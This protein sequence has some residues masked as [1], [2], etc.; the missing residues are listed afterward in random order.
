MCECAIH[1]TYKKHDWFGE[2]KY[3]LADFFDKWWDIYTQ[4]PTSFIQPE[5]YKAVN[6]IRTCRTAA[7]GID[8]YACPQ[9]GDTTEIYHNCK[10]RFCPTCSWNDTVRWAEK[11]KKNML[12]MPHR[13]VVFTIPHQ[14][15]PLIKRNEYALLNM[16]IQVSADTLKSWIEHKYGLR[17]G[18]ISVLHTFGELK[19]FHSH[20]HMIV[21]WGGV[22]KTG[23]IKEIKGEYVKY[24]F[25]QS[26]FRYNYENK[27][28][29][30][31]DSDKLQHDFKDRVEFMRFLKSIN[32][33]NWIIH[34]EAPMDTPAAVIR[35]IGRYSKRAC[36][37][38]YK[39]TR[40]EEENIG[41]RYKD[42]RNR[43]F[44]GHPIEKE[45]ILNYRKFFP[46]L[47]QHVPL[48]YF[49]MVRYYGIYS[50]KGHLPKEY[51]DQEDNLPIDWAS[52]QESKTG[53]NPLFCK[54][55]NMD[56]VYVHC[57]IQRKPVINNLSRD[58]SAY[59]QP[60]IYKRKIV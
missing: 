10:N 32:E 33:K 57:I 24:E 36:L 15:I 19:N 18:I 46:L 16:Q 23:S 56:K 2:K 44:N 50:N 48:P 41:F 34:F 5:Q 11:I 3:R 58:E 59:Y 52:T 25:L 1:T 42:Y 17:I 8:I 37:S 21:S 4:N 12:N 39:I 27:L 54:K 29:E 40:M 20:V 13:H 6:A 26:K 31:F 45:L 43:D 7:L 30:L 47:L 53:E 9:C 55:C 51:F 49:R 28:I 60:I 38:E 14:L 35:Y 22:D